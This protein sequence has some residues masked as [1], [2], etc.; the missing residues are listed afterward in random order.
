MLFHEKNF[1]TACLPFS[2]WH[3]FISK[4][5]LIATRTNKEKVRIRL[6]STLFLH[7][8][9]FTGVNGLE[10]TLEM[11]ITIASQAFFD[12]LY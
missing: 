4:I 2:T 6:L 7:Q 5:S 9:S 11:G 8:K 3:R 10:V 1:T 12:I